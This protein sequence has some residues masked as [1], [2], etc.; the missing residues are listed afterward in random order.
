[1][2][3]VLAVRGYKTVPSLFRLGPGPQHEAG[4]DLNST[5]VIDSIARDSLGLAHVDQ[6]ASSALARS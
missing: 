6:S 3:G 1:M 5:G 4:R 2:S